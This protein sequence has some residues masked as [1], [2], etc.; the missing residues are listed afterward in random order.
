MPKSTKPKEPP[1]DEWEFLN[2]LGLPRKAVFCI[3]DN[4][5]QWLEKLDRMNSCPGKRRKKR[6]SLGHSRGGVEKMEH[7]FSV[8]LENPP[9]TAAFG[10][11][12]IFGMEPCR[13][14]LHASGPMN[15]SFFLRFPYLH[16]SCISMLINA[17]G[18]SSDST[19]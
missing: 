1:K 9:V 8:Q 16:H 2:N 17:S 12:S 11:G 5:L 4:L 15:R 7:A 14:D 6:R 10:R 19:A 3:F 18:S 13:N